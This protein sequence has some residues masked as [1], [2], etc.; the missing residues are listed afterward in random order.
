M[1]NTIETTHVV[2]IAFVSGKLKIL[3]ISYAYGLTPVEP[4]E[5][6]AP[7]TKLNGNS[8]KR[9][10]MNCFKKELTPFLFSFCKI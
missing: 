1:I 2:N 3:P 9:Y 6:S 5:V 8:K 7:N 10:V 4:P